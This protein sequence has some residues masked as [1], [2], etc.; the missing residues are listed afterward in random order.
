MKLHWAHCEAGLERERYSNF[1]HDNHPGVDSVQGLGKYYPRSNSVRPDGL[2]VPNGEL[3]QRTDEIARLT[4]NEYV[5]YD[6]PRVKIRYLLKFEVEQSPNIRNALLPML[7]LLNVN[8]VNLHLNPPSIQNPPNP[9]NVQN[10]A[11]P[12][13]GP[14]LAN[15]PNLRNLLSAARLLTLQNQPNF[16][17]NPNASYLPRN[18]PN[19]PPS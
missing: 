10:P 15:P 7:P 17:N 8:R 19:A 6:E 14:V 3:V 11:I 9:P 5:V 12:P 13:N 4:F 2:I 16:S 1:D 18:P